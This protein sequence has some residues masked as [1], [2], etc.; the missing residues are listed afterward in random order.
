M[1]Q[2]AAALQSL[3]EHRIRPDVRA[4]HAYAVQD[5]TGMVKLD[6][7]EN[8]FPLPPALQA[9]L[10]ARLGAVALHRYPG[11]RI[12]DLRAALARQ[13]DMPA[14]FDIMLGNGSDE[15]ISLLSVACNLCAADPASA[16]ARVI[17]PLPGFVMYAMSAQLT[18]LQFVG[19]DLDANFGLDA[20]A[21]CAAIEQ[22]RPALVYLAIRIIRPPICGTPAPCR[23]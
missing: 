8:P 9:A 12:N 15:L 11:P 19:V 20:P 1:P 6:A 14:G 4:M 22:H 5:A 10:G 7:M 17:A 3:I 18:G 2:A 23:P 16:A 21:M 13:S